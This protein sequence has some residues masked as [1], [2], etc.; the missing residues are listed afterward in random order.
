MFDSWLKIPAHYYLRITALVLLVVGVALSNVLMSI[1]AIWIAANWL[2]EADFR[3]CS[4]R[5]KKSPEVWLIIGLVVYLIISLLWSDDLAYGAKD[6]RVKLP[7]LA[8]PLAL[9]L[10]KPLESKIVYFLF[11]IFIA[12]V[13]LTASWNFIS[14]NY[15]SD[16]TGDIR[17]MSK[18][19]S[20]IRFATLVNLAI[21][22][23][24][25]LWFEERLKFFIAIPI[26]IGLVFY[27]LKAQVLNGYLLLV[28]LSLYTVLYIIRK[29]E[30]KKVKWLFGLLLVSL[31]A[32]IIVI[33]S[34]A[35]KTYRGLDPTPFEN[36]E[37]YSQNGEPYFH[38]TTIKQTENG[39]YIWLYVAQQELESAWNRRSTIDYDSVDQ[40]GQPMFGTVMRY[41]TSKNL[42]KDS[43][44][45]YSL[46]EEEIRQIE[47]GKTS[48]NMN[49]GLVAKIHSFLFEY[50]MYQGGGDPN[51]FSL[52]QRIEH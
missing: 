16:G 37:L 19:I 7:L 9:G 5:A 23:T 49:N 50:E 51:G 15:L 10:G 20:Q 38:D 24:V 3:N 30:L 22:I 39:H 42:R 2:I 26:I 29:L 1:G 33:V 27:T 41:M 25:M 21:F 44:G 47:K 4:M 35:L 12:V 31:I 14:Y 8:I 40:K 18:F 45:V 32:A 36:L 6:L 13:C 34:G 48:V 28:V 46:S 43:V 11:Y 52:L 17:E